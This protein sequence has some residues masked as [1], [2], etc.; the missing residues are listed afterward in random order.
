MR[1]ELLWIL[2]IVLSYGGPWLARRFLGLTGLY[3]WMALSLIAANILVLINITLLGLNATLGNVAYN[4]NFL[5]TDTLCETSDSRT[6]R[7][8]VWVGFFA[9]ISFMVMINIGLLFQPALHDFAMP[10]L[11][12]IFTLFPRIVAGSL[13]A[14]FISQLHDVW[15]YER[16]RRWLPAR[17]FLWLRNNGSTVVSQLIDSVIFC[18]IAL[19][20]I[21]DPPIF[22]EILLTTYG[23]KVAAALLDTPFVYRL[24][25]QRAVPTPS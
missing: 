25:R 20:G 5:V 8:A 21:Y 18:F 24:T 22:F 6:A 13:V 2:L 15:L 14:Y 19:W 23:F 9:L 7:R 11:Q 3:I 4:T 12:A 17:K 10:H 16:L 1:N